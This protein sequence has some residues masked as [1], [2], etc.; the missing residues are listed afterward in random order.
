MR[1]RQTPRTPVRETASLPDMDSLSLKDDCAR[2]KRFC[3]FMDTSPTTYHAVHY[4]SKDLENAGFRPLN[5]RDS[6]EDEFH[7]H[8]KFYVTRNGSS[9]IAF[10]VGKDWTPAMEPE[11]L[12]PTLTLCVPRS[13]LSLRKPPSTATLSSEPRPT[14]APFPT[15]GGTVTWVSPAELSAETAT[16][17]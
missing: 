13:N 6:W 4:L 10:V 14:P 15:P 8:D 1:T 17:R 9:I 5:E 2:A 16:T 11:S 12:A 7:T 3:D